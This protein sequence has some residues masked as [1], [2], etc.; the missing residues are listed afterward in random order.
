M[1]ILFGAASNNPNLVRARQIG[2]VGGLT[3]LLDDA[4]DLVTPVLYARTQRLLGA[5]LRGEQ[6]AA[7]LD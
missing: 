5:P 6:E 4:E 1:A 2:L 3:G 7:G